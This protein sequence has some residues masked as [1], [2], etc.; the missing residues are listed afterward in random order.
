MVG[1]RLKDGRLTRRVRPQPLPALAV[2]LHRAK[3]AAV[4]HPSLL[5]ARGHTI[6]KANDALR[7]LAGEE[8]AARIVARWRPR[9]SPSD[10]SARGALV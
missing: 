6:R 7:Q 3:A 2:G 4:G 5:T 8:G 9:R 10:V 1:S